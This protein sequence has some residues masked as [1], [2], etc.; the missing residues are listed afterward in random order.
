MPPGLLPPVTSATLPARPGSIMPAARLWAAGDEAGP[1]HVQ[2]RLGGLILRL[3][4]EANDAPVRLAFRAARFQDR[5]PHT[6]RVA[7]ADRTGPADLVHAGRAH[8]GRLAED[9]IY[10][11]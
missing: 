10:Q 1:G 11:Q 4:P 9:V 5:Q 3:D 7:R 6:Q 8:V 2:D